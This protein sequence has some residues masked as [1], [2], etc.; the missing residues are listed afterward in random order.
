VPDLTVHTLKRSITIRSASDATFQY[1]AGSPHV[2]SYLTPATIDI[3]GEG[4]FLSAS[5][6]GLAPAFLTRTASARDLVLQL[7]SEIAALSLQ[8]ALP[9]VVLAASVLHWRGTRLLL[10]GPALSRTALA[11]A[12]FA[13]GV[14][15]EGD[16]VCRLSPAGFTALPRSIRWD[17]KLLHAF[18]QVSEVTEGFRS[19]RLDSFHG[20]LKAWSPVAADRPWICRDGALDGIV[21]TDNNGGGRSLSRRIAPDFVWGYLMAARMSGDGGTAL[22]AE[23]KSLADSTP[24]LK[25]SVGDLGDATHAIMHFLSM[26]EGRSSPPDGVAR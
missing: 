18:P 1:L 5:W 7:D 25:L 15:I 23:L 19:H 2:S 26:L 4:T 16:W 17:A 3:K 11:L 8:D 20:E 10:L 14:D 22:M 12:L 9:D 13:R 24:A 6:C 21:A